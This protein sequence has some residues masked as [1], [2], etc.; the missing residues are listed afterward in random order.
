MIRIF[1]HYVPTSILVLGL[2][3]AFL[4]FFAIE[5]AAQLRF[6]EANLQ[7]GALSSRLLEHVVYVMVVMLSIS[8]LGLYQTEIC[9]DLRVTSIRLIFGLGV[10]LVVMSV[11]F[12]LIP[13][14]ALWRSIFAIAVVISFVIIMIARFVFIRVVDINRFKRRVAVL[15]AGKRALRLKDLE[16][17][18]PSRGFKIVQFMAQPGE[19]QQISDASCFTDI[20]TLRDYV[21]E[22][23]IE[24]VVLAMEERR[25]QLPVNELLTCRM[26]GTRITDISSFIEREQGYVDL[27]MVNPSWL[28]FSD[29][30][31]SLNRAALV[32]KRI[33][34]VVVSLLILIFA[35]PIWVPTAIAIKLTSRGPVLYRQERVGQGGD[36]FKALKFRSMRVD[37]EKDGIP[38][39][40]GENDPRITPFGRVIRAARIDEIPQVYNVLRG[41]M[42][43]V[44]PRPE[45]PYFVD[46][47]STEIPYY[48]ERH[49]VKPGITGW[50]QLN[51]SYGASIED[52]RRKLEF[53]LYYIKNYSLF[54]DVLILI[55]TARVVLWPDGVR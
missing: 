5:L 1:K 21:R 32:S 55:Q 20:G 38:K 46:Q 11:V 47:L 10:S 34:D 33:F 48:A 13:D 54:L 9:R 31:I 42:S 18:S 43:F 51:Y 40:A 41:D 23:R 36:V 7:I 19:A 53:D 14:V 26:S 39:W 3:E 4:L 24:E 45:R 22:N 29:G 12:F 50:A 25:G 35:I 6:A 44:G 49:H 28:I 30:F 2:V 37:A 27:D 15:G 52:A 8:A 16:E 17:S